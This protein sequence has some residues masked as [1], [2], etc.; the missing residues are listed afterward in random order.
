MSHLNSTVALIG[1][2]TDIGAGRRG[3]WMGPEALRGAGLAEAL[4]GRGRT[5]VATGNRAGAADPG[6]PPADGYRHL[7]EVVAWSR[8]VMEAG[9]G[10][11]QAGPL[12]ILLGGDHCGGLGGTTAVA[13]H[14][15]EQG[16]KLR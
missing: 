9:Y 2:P 14:C 1:A 13:R 10:Q 6:Q 8:A 11:L 4:R 15:R 5:V 3:A 12:P 16:R 7:A